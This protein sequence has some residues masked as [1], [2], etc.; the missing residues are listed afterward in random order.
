METEFKEKVQEITPHALQ[1]Y[2]TEDVKIQE[3]AT[4]RG[5]IPV[6]YE[7]G[8]KP[9]YINKNLSYQEQLLELYNYRT[10]PP[11]NFSS[12]LIDEQV[13]KMF[14]E[15][16][17]YYDR[18]GNLITVP[19]D[20]WRITRKFKNFIDPLSK[21]I[22]G[23]Q[24]ESE[25]KREL[26]LVKELTELGLTEDK[27]SRISE[28]MKDTTFKDY[29]LT[30]APDEGDV[31]FLM[32]VQNVVANIYDF[33]PTV[34]GAGIWSWKKVREE[35]ADV[36]ALANQEITFEEYEAQEQDTAMRNLERTRYFDDLRSRIPLIAP[37]KDLYRTMIF[38][39][40]QHKFGEGIELTD[41]QMNLMF[42]EGPIT[43]QIARIAAEALPYIVAIEGILIKGYGLARGSKAYDKALEFVSKNTHKYGSPYEA[44]IKYMEQDAM[45]KVWI[46][47][48]K[49]KTFM[50]N[51]IKRYDKTSKKMTKIEKSAIEKDIKRIENEIIDADRLNDIVKVRNLKKQKDILL[52]KHAGLKVRWLNN[53]T[54]ATIR[55][56]IYAST[57]GGTIYSLTGSDGWAL[58]GELTGA[59]MEP[60]LHVAA[61]K[62]V[63][64][65]IFRVGSLIDGL[66]SWYLLPDRVKVWSDK[67]LKAKFF[68]GDVADLMIKD[69]KSGET[70]ALKL[71]EIKNLRRFAEI[72]E[73]I[74]VK[75]RQRILARMEKSQEAMDELKKFLPEDQQENLKMTIAEMTGLSV[76]NAL[77]ELTKINMKITNIKPSDILEANNNIIQTRALIQSIDGRVKALLGSVDGKP[78]ALL[79]DFGKKIEESL[80]MMEKDLLVR[81]QSYEELFDIFSDGLMGGDILANFDKKSKNFIE[82]AQ[83]LEKLRE[84]AS[85][86]AVRTT[87]DNIIATY[88]QKVMKHW[89][90]VAKDLNNI[91]SGAHGGYIL[92]DYLAS[93]F[94]DTLKVLFDSKVKK[95]YTDIDT[96]TKGTRIDVTD[97]YIELAGTVNKN[98]GDKIGSLANKLPPGHFNN[99]IMAVIE[100][101]A[102]DSMIRYLDTGDGR[103]IF[104]GFIADSGD[105]SELMLEAVEILQQKQVLTKTDVTK[106]F[107]ALAETL[108][109]ET[110]KYKNLS[111]NAITK[112]DI[113]DI[114]RDGGIDININL[115]VSDAM[116]LRSGLSSAKYRAYQAGEGAQALNYDG[117]T[118]SMEKSILESLVTT[119]QKDAYNT[120]LDLAVDFHNRFDNESS[121]LFQWGE[122]SR[123]PLAYRRTENLQDGI[124]IETRKKQSSPNSKK[125]LDDL[126]IDTDMH[127]PNMVHT[128]GRGEFIKWDK[129]LNDPVYA[130]KF[131]HEVI[132]PLVGKPFTDATM[133]KRVSP[134]QTHYIDMNDAEVAQRAMI[135][136]KL[137]QQEL[138]SFFSLT[139]TGQDLMSFSKRQDILKLAREKNITM[140][141][142]VKY[143]PAIER[144]F[145]ITD[146]FSVLNTHL[147][148]EANM[149]Y[150]M[151]LA[152]SKN[153]QA[154]DKQIVQAI[155][156][157]LKKARRVLKLDFQKVKTNIK[158]ISDVRQVAKLGADLGKPDIFYK[159]IILG[160]NLTAYK[161][162]ESVLTEGSNAIMTKADFKKAAQT[163]Y[164][165][166]YTHHSGLRN[167]RTDLTQFDMVSKVDETAGTVNKITQ[168][169]AEGQA[170][171]TNTYEVNLGGAIDEFTKHKDILYELFGKEGVD[172]TTEVLQ[173]MAAKSGVNIDNV[174]LQNMPKTLSVES[175]ISR[176]YSINRGVI[177]PRY[178]LTEAALQKFR[179]QSTEMMIDLMSQPDA[180]KMIKKLIEDGVQKSPYLDL[181]L[182]KFFQSKVVS[183]I[184]ANE[185]MDEDGEL[186][187]HRP[188]SL[189]GSESTVGKTIRWP[190]ST[191]EEPTIIKNWLQQERL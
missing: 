142:E 55:N 73:V 158:K 24:G 91:S 166:W 160:N 69:K 133:V 25:T 74:P 47:E 134:N 62:A 116:D 159:N 76:L 127:V 57:I 183:A 106:V 31:P 48:A 161:A 33:V 103:Q 153:V 140:P 101:G 137:M 149:G 70:R 102:N 23:W 94:H 185:M 77:D 167:I 9:V 37:Y 87:V 121:L 129:I 51:V 15:T 89:D 184:V 18:K 152:L 54:K 125:V 191:G 81:Q 100:Q 150:N 35:E 28:A 181:R 108:T 164:R 132:E 190:F 11:E 174:N 186:N 135:F 78:D 1:F 179:V 45:R 95:A 189:V 171:I 32:Q 177:S 141:S 131:L 68:T 29:L 155:R 97:T 151:A 4:I 43:Y 96:I 145:K 138:A 170:K 17:Q 71:K 79:W 42:K 122:M 105:P 143:N 99:K 104:A 168:A 12:S 112:L 147:V 52:G 187:I 14:D 162:M 30:T 163:L 113:Y 114:L 64:N 66:N 39:A 72:F 175:W 169:L 88:E 123:P 119:E 83:M 154:F 3:A 118:S 128:L 144:I 58:G 19:D 27:Q 5:D 80:Q 2:F 26:E 139:K 16:R 50:N 178:V 126:K 21:T 109:K 36:E 98:R 107:D 165:E 84:N 60:N 75:D 176:I 20:E 40:T 61:T 115:K 34:T 180:A 59:I 92:Q 86:D 117:M 173:S 6:G 182:R 130:E 49:G 156:K 38:N 53:Y 65:T 7:N 22:P 56:E 13:S 10:N 111:P 67:N 82:T 120:A 8:V 44:M 110:P 148:T 157:D 188:D 124:Q 63:A 90:N 93:D 85:S 136:K 146:D 172:S 41:Q 46:G